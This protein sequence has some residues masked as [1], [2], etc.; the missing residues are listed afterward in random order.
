M[1]RA[2]VLAVL[3]AF[4][5]APGAAADSF[6]D[7]E[8]VTTAGSSPVGTVGGG[9]E[10]LAYATDGG[11]AVVSRTPGG[12][13]GLPHALD[14]GPPEGIE[15]S[16]G[17]DV[18]VDLGED[19]D[20]R[21]RFAVRMPSGVWSAVERTAPGLDDARVALGPDGT[22]YAAGGGANGTVL[23]QSRPQGGALGTPALVEDRWADEPLPKRIGPLDLTVL[24]ATAYGPD[25]IVGW[26]A[27]LPSFGGTG[28]YSVHV[29]SYG[30]RRYIDYPFSSGRLTALDLRSAGRFTAFVTTAGDYQFDGRYDQDGFGS[31][32][33]QRRPE[34]STQTLWTGLDGAQ[35]IATGTPQGVSVRAWRSSENSSVGWGNLARPGATG[36]GVPVAAVDS[37][38]RAVLMWS[39]SGPD[40]RAIV[41]RR[42]EGFAD[43]CEARVVGAG[44]TVGVP[45][46]ALAPHGG[47]AAWQAEGTTT[48]VA[49][50]YTAA[51][52]CDPPPPPDTGRAP[53]SPGK[54]SSPPVALDTLEV[55]PVARVDRRGRR[56]VLGLRCRAQT[57]CRGTV[58]LRRGSRTLGTRTFAVAATRRR[59]VPVTLNRA[60]RRSTRGRRVRAT[61]AVRAAGGRWLAQSVVLRR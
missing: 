58:R 14:A 49:S 9:E 54:P 19:A 53:E 13:F 3:F 48:I 20:G 44:R 7:A 4:G 55:E 61:A 43:W 17:G 25:V 33:G 23:L 29:T 28:L 18:L 26:E 27:E 41:F 42:S 46:L 36:F 11:T 1:R 35:A 52:G 59:G 57:A 21:R 50:R 31:G 51:P 30:A 12:A 38:A 40:G 16:P 45:V 60:G 32:G 15:A 37:G 47:F 39:E 2:L 22:V 6:T 8:L 24:P 56:A 10:L 5:M 34:S